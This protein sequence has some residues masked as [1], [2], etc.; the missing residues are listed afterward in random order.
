MLPG[1]QPAFSIEIPGEV[2]GID[3]STLRM[4]VSRVG[5]GGVI[6]VATCSLVRA[7][8]L[9]LRQARAFQTLRSFFGVL[10][11]RWGHPLAVGVEAPLTGGTTPLASFYVIGAMY[12]AL[13]EALAGTRGTF[14]G[15][16]I[17]E[18]NP[19]QWKR[20]A[21]GMG[22]GRF[23]KSLSK[24]KRRELEKQRLLEWAWTVGYTGRLSDEADACGVGVATALKV[25]RR[26]K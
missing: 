4:S 2:W 7:D 19:P 13:G 22:Y 3:P 11:G 8:W 17:V 14:G 25:G 10:R 23:E 6:D 21:T 15:P 20:A 26:P 12:A 1:L 18:F 24:A 5:A 9:P 16:E